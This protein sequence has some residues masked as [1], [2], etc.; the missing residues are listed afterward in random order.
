MGNTECFRVQGR[1]IAEVGDKIYETTNLKT[2]LYRTAHA[3]WLAYDYPINYYT[4]SPSAGRYSVAVG[5]GTAT[6]S[7]A[8]AALGNEIFRKAVTVRYVARTYSARLMTTFTTLEPPVFPGTTQNTITEY[9]L[10]DES[11]ITIANS[12]FNTWTGGSANSWLSSGCTLSGTTGTA[13][14]YEPSGSVA[15]VVK[16]SG[17]AKVYQNITFDNS[18]RS[19]SLT[20][21]LAVKEKTKAGSQSYLYIYDGVNYTYGNPH[22]GGA[23]TPY[24]VL[25]VTK[26][27]SGTAGTLQI[28]AMVPTG[29]AWLDWANLTPDGKLLARATIDIDKGSTQPMNLTWDIYLDEIEEGETMGYTGFAFE[30]INVGTATAVILGTAYYSPAGSAAAEKAVVSIDD[31]NI[32]Y[33]YDGGTPSATVGHLAYIGDMFTLTGFTNIQNFKAI[34]MGAGSAKLQV[35]YEH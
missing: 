32:R 4:G 35:T 28:G 7:A 24:S 31:Y 18:W 27:L 6:P 25:S 2:N 29:T 23:G 34:S 1:V 14:W 5:T 17:T 22:A 15:Q 12:S 3:N 16:T 20:F 26:T 11:P 30:S 10:F 21:R 9:G 19:Q 8:D 13:Y 33:K